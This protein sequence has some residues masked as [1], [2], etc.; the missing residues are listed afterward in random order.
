MEIA[1]AKLSPSDRLL[2]VL[3]YL[4]E[5]SGDEVAS[6]MGVKLETLHVRLHRARQKLK[7]ILTSE[8]THEQ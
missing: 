4:E 8:G 6:S 2:L 7:T 3:Y 5:M 1:L